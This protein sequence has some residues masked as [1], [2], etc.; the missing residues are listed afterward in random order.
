MVQVSSPLDR[1]E[2]AGGIHRRTSNTGGTA[3]NANNIGGLP[4]QQLPNSFELD[5]CIAVISL[6]VQWHH[7]S[8]FRDEQQNNHSIK[9]RLK[10]E[11]K[12]EFLHVGYGSCAKDLPLQLASLMTAIQ[13]RN[14]WILCMVQIKLFELKFSLLNWQGRIVVE[15]G[16][17]NI[18]GKQLEE[19]TRRDWK[20]YGL[21]KEEIS[22]R[23]KR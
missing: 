8:T 5:T 7:G 19:N 23:R 6:W 22:S 3:N 9:Q 16:K 4:S 12:K 21:V 18:L 17:K 13:P 11:E 1:L 10:P 15:L 14:S 20:E 2:V